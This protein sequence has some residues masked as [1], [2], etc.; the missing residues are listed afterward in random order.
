MSDNEYEELKRCLKNL[1]ETVNNIDG[2]LR[3]DSYRRKGII[4][5]HERLKQD[6]NEI[7]KIKPVVEE[8]LLPKVNNHDSFKNRLFGIIIGV[9][10]MTGIITAMI[11]WIISNG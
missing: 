3:G 4:H 9:S 2:S 10:S 6:V 7:K 1:Q 8:E 11:V 5:E